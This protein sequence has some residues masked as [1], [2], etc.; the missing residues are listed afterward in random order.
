MYENKVYS[1]GQMVSFELVYLIGQINQ[2]P[3]VILGTIECGNASCVQS[4]QF[5]QVFDDLIIEK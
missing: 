3:L 1:Y 5:S 4:G 2:N